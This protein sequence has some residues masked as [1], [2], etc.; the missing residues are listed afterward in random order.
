MKN[1]PGNLHTCTKPSKAPL[2]RSIA[3]AVL[4]SGFFG[5]VLAGTTV[6]IPNGSSGDSSVVNTSTRTQTSTV[7]GLGSNYSTAIS[8]NG[9]VAYAASYFANAVYPINTTTNAVGTAITVGSGPTNVTFS[10][11]SA[12]VYVSNRL[13]N[14]ISVIDVST[15]ALSST[16]PTVTSV[17]PGTTRPFQ[18]V[19]HG[20]KLLIACKAESAGNPS[21]VMSMNTAASNAL[22]ELATV[23][24]S[25][26]NIAISAL[27]GFGYVTNYDSNSISKFD[28]TTGVTTHY[29]TTGVTTPL[30]LAVTPDG[31]KIYVGG[32]T[33]S[34]LIV[35]DPNGAV[36]TTLNLGGTAIA[37][38]GMSSNGS[39]IYAPLVGTGAGIKVI[40][41]A[42]DVVTATIANPGARVDI[43]WGD[44]L[45]NVSIN[46]APTA[47]AVAVSGTAQAGSTLTGSYT[48]TDADSDAQGSS[49]FRWVKNNVNTGVGGGTNVGTSTTYT[50][51]S[52]DVGS[53]MYYCVT[54]VASAGVTTGTEVCSAASAAV[55]AAPVPAPIPTLSEWAM[56][57]MASLMGL[58]AFTRIRRQ[59]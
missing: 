8:P 51:L 48:Y 28:L 40:S 54:P 41:T 44:F 14:S 46:T 36:L 17:C 25:A 3:F 30:G 16:I 1:K 38:L 57:L 50:P 20:T 4:L 55:A 45:G 35:M 43:I 39:V 18:S 11:N 13:S 22:T 58:F 7:T 29:P 9:N 12:L 37:G 47:S 34:N 6:Y 15:G 49:T 27:S 5:S 23:Q 26:Y 24:N 42:T 21:K 2:A 59:S 19:F 31:S 52:G 53:F 33:G 10:S 56:I 32:Q